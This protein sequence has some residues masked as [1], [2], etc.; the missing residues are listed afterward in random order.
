MFQFHC[1]VNQIRYKHCKDYCF[2]VSKSTQAKDEFNKTANS[3]KLA[4]K[5]VI[6]KLG[7]ILLF[8]F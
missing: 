1:T 5:F 3:A 6:R 8:R 4:R 7:N 2:R